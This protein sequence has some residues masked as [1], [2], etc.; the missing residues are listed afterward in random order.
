M[1]RRRGASGAYAPCGARQRLFLPANRDEGCAA[2]ALRVPRSQRTA[3]LHAG[4]AGEDS[5]VRLAHRLED[6]DDRAGAAGA[7][8][9][10]VAPSHSASTN[11]AGSGGQLACNSRHQRRHFGIPSCPLLGCRAR[12]A[13]TSGRSTASRVA[14]AAPISHWS[15]AGEALPRNAPLPATPCPPASRMRAGSPSCL[16][17]H[18]A[19]LCERPVVG[20]G[21]WMTAPPVPACRYHLFVGNPCPWC[22]R[23]LLALAV[24]GLEDVV[25]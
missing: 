20:V 9:A 22:H 12:T 14:S 24:C 18:C 15:P 11:L 13:P 19:L 5:Q 4:D 2:P 1:D 25:R 16:S 17:S 7:G 8:C 23:V 10:C 3:G 6:A 21:V